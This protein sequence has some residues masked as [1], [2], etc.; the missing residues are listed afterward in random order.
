[1]AVTDL[2]SKCEAWGVSQGAKYDALPNPEP[3][4]RN[5]TP[6]CAIWCSLFSHEC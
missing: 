6:R 1:L 4:R 5:L 2:S 3:K